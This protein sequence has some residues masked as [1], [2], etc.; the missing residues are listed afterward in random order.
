[1]SSFVRA[2]LLIIGAL[3]MMKKNI[4]ELSLNVFPFISLVSNTIHSHFPDFLVEHNILPVHY[5]PFKTK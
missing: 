4:R 5:V 1:M 2:V 3:I